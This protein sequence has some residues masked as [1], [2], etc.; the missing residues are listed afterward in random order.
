MKPITLARSNCNPIGQTTDLKPVLIRK[1]IFMIE[2][3]Y[4]TSAVL[5][6]KKHFRHFFTPITI[7]NDFVDHAYVPLSIESSKEGYENEIH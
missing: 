5:F 3:I 4:F 7:T 2:V 6:P 1:M